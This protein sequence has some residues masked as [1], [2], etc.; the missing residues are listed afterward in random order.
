MRERV[1]KWAKKLASEYHFFL[2][3][4]SVKM[5]KK[6]KEDGFKASASVKNKDNEDKTSETI[7]EKSEEEELLAKNEKNKQQS[8]RLGF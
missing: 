3:R 7:D 1:H 5:E 2:S 8:A 4:W 6:F